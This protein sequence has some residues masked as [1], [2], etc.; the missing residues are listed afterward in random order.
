MD[1]FQLV[2]RSPQDGDYTISIKDDAWTF[3]LGDG[4]G[5]CQS[6]ILKGLVDSILLSSHQNVINLVCSTPS[7]ASLVHLMSNQTCAELY[8]GDASVSS[9]MKLGISNQIVLNIRSDGGVFTSIKVQPIGQ[10]AV[11]SSGSA[12]MAIV[13]LCVHGRFTRLYYAENGVYGGVMIWRKLRI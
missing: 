9:R 13:R 12:Q 6:V 1:I 3:I 10:R 8:C 4:I 11:L 7:I 2:L 5:D